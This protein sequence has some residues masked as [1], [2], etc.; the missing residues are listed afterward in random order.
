MT[1]SFTNLKGPAILSL[2]LVLPFML[3]EVVSRRNLPESFPVFLFSL[4]WLLPTVFIITLM[5]MVRT[6]RAGNSLIANPV[7]LLLKVVLLA[8]VAVVWASLLMD[9]MPCFL[10]VPNCD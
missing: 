6:V 8:V 10:G 5:P 9:Q 7:T 4:L 2:I 1:T 3:L